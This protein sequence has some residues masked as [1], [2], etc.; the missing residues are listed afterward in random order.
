MT[1]EKG[2]ACEKLNK[3]AVIAESCKRVYDSM[4]DERPRAKPVETC[5]DV[6]DWARVGRWE[7][8]EPNF[9]KQVCVVLIR[10]A[11]ILRTSK[12]YDREKE[13]GFPAK[14]HGS[15]LLNVGMWICYD[16]LIR[17]FSFHLKS[18]KNASQTLG[19]SEKSP[20]IIPTLL[21][22]IGLSFKP[23]SKF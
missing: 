15:I 18:N 7:Q 5:K 9:E 12:A 16:L 23:T 21:Q 20:I 1:Y 17:L 22:T 14:S 3:R 19:K 8:L 11:G 4:S 6:G 13:V 10:T 2:N